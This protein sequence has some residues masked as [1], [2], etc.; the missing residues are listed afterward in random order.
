MDDGEEKNQE[1]DPIFWLNIE[2]VEDL[3][4]KSGEVIV[5]I[6]TCINNQFHQI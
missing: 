4:E 1:K 3:L 2:P 5:I 6:E